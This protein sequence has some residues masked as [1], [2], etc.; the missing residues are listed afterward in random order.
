[1]L[2][3]KQDIS[4]LLKEVTKCDVLEDGF[5]DYGR[6]RQPETVAVILKKDGDDLE[7]F[8]NA[9]E[10]LQRLRERLPNGFVAYVGTTEW[11]SNQVEHDNGIELAVGKGDSQFDILRLA[12]TDACNYDMST[13][14]LIAPL[15]DLDRRFGIDIF[16]AEADRIAILFK[17]LPSDMKSLAKELFEYCEDLSQCDIDEDDLIEILQTGQSI[18]FWWD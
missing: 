9:V 18:S 17:S 8:G 10:F 2:K 4:G 7:K 6:E 15:E 3:W 5:C 16:Q 12:K 1:M 13:E 11:L 14:D